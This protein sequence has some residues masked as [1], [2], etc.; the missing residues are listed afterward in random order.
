MTPTES[1]MLILLALLDTVLLVV[2]VVSLSYVRYHL[3]LLTE[4]ICA[5]SIRLEKL[6]PPCNAT[7][8]SGKPSARLLVD[9]AFKPS[10]SRETAREFLAR[11]DPEYKRAM[12]GYFDYR[13]SP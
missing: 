1:T 2:V 9:T 11:V 13:R 4:S 5:A 6:Q 8:P 12:Q 7:N 3:T 10:P